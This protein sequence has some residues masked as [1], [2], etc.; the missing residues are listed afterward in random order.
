M[1]SQHLYRPRDSSSISSHTPWALKVAKTQR[2]SI[3]ALTGGV[4]LLVINVKLENPQWQSNRT[5]QSH[6]TPCSYEA[7]GHSAILTE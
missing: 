5:G 3:Y 7:T 2:T 1:I 6:K 4:G